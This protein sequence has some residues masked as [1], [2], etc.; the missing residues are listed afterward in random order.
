[1][2]IHR[3]QHIAIALALALSAAPAGAAIT[4]IHH[5]DMNSAASAGIDS[6]GGLNLTMTGS[7]SNTA[8]VVG[9]AQD[10]T[11][12]INDGT[13]ESTATNYLDG[14]T[15]PSPGANWGVEMWVR[16]DILPDGAAQFEVG[17]IHLGPAG[18]GGLALEIGHHPSFGDG[19][20]G[21]LSHAPGVAAPLHNA[22]QG[23]AAPTVGAWSHLAYI[24]DGGVST[25]YVDG[26]ASSVAPP[27]VTLAGGGPDATIGS[28]WVDNRRGF[29][30]AIDEVRIFTFNPG[31]FD[32]NDTLFA[33]PEPSSLALVGLASL[34]LLRRRR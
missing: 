5:Y 9:S 26:V 4:V 2:K 14:A 16:P 33:I 1:M 25:F 21:W 23:V 7:T 24:N 19:N 31:E 20:V 17:L 3:P 6:V 10:F 32:I 28:M 30:G 15:A 8:G 34:G 13:G 29:D 11:N 22:V 12:G 18:G 27:A